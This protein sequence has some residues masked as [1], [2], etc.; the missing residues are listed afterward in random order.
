MDSLHVNYVANNCS[1]DRWN[2]LLLNPIECGTGTHNFMV[3]NEDLALQ[4]AD[5]FD[6]GIISDPN[7]FDLYN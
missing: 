1:G 4:L 5:S 2:Y 6:C 7:E 3:K